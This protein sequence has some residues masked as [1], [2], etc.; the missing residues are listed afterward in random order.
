MHA[1]VEVG[2]ELSVRL[3]PD[4]AILAS[5]STDHTVVL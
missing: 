2:A 5:R 3:S 1:Q 4:G